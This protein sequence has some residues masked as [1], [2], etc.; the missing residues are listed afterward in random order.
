MEVGPGGLGAD[1]TGFLVGGG[2]SG[3]GPSFDRAAFDLSLPK[4]VTLSEFSRA[5]N[6][7]VDEP[8]ARIQ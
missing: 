3:L 7:P 2:G 1:E 4:H 6:G 5:Y 8:F